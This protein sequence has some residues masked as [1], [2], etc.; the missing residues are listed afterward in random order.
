MVKGDQTCAPT[1]VGAWGGQ[2]KVRFRRWAETNFW[3]ALN[4]RV[5]VLD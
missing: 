4:V 1:G 2:S 3:K 5:R